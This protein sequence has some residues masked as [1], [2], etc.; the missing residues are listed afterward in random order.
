MTKV[1]ELSERE[2]NLNNARTN[3]RECV[4]LIDELLQGRVSPNDN[5]RS[6]VAEIVGK[7]E[8]AIQYLYRSIEVES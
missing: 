3:L 8:W 7:A 5:M 2:V 1:S 4:Q 6:T